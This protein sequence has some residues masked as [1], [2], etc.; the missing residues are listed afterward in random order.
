M[1]I[2]LGFKKGFGRIDILLLAIL[3]L[4][5]AC[6]GYPEEPRNPKI[7]D[8]TYIVEE[9]GVLNVTAENGILGNDLAQEGN[10]LEI[11]DVGELETDYGGKVVMAEDGSFTYQPKENFNGRD[12]LVYTVENERGK[13]SDGIVYFQV[14]SVNDPPVPQDDIF[15]SPISEAITIQ[16][17]ENDSDPD[18]DPLQLVDVD[19]PDNGSVEIDGGNMVIYRPSPD[20]TGIARFRYTVTD[21]NGGRAAAWVSLNVISRDNSIQV[22]PD[23]LTVSEDV[24]GE[25]PISILVSNDHDLYGGQLSVVGIGEAENGIVTQDDQN[26]SYAPNP[27][28]FGTDGFTYTVESSESGYTASSMVTVTVTPVNDPPTIS[29]I[30]DQSVQSGSISQA[31]GFTIEDLDNSFAEL[32]VRPEVFNVNP[33]G[34]ITNADV[35]ISGDNQHRSLRIV[36]RPGTQGGADVAVIVD[37]GQES[38]SEIF[39]LTVLPPL[40]GLFR[41]FN[42][43]FGDHFYTITR[44]DERLAAFGYRYEGVQCQVHALPA[45]GAVPLYRHY[46]STTGDHFYTTTPNEPALVNTG[47]TPEGIACYVFSEQVSGTVPLYRYYNAVSGDHFYTTN[48]VELSMGTAAYRYEGVACFVYP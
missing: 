11:Y 37:D 42:G 41:Y 28:F 34:L 43:T 10:Q 26:L 3:W 2:K 35:T 4:L 24:P 33:S 18:G 45:P 46:H 40:T 32:S 47:Y 23:T 29:P 6:A 39:R 38:S 20:H 15:N 44:N 14:T 31:I 12:Q 19:P 9:D 13:S 25:F 1:M 22:T 7:S 21:P 16:V 8:D 30:Y 48:W 17:L 27:D 5:T 36:T